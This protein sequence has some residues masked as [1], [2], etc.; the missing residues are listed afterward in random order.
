MSAVFDNLWSSYSP[1]I[2]KTNWDWKK[3]PVQRSVKVWFD[4]P[5]GTQGE[6]THKTV[7]V[8]QLCRAYAKMYPKWGDCENWDTIGSD[9]C[10]QMALF[11][12]VIYA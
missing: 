7:T 9:V 1:W 4:N 10:L 8:K 12:K 6:I 11:G 5:E 3:E 2:S